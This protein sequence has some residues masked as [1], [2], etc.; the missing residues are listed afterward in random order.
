[1]DQFEQ[2]NGIAKAERDGFSREQI[3]KSFYVQTEGLNTMQRREIITEFF[4]REK[5]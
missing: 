1:M 5:K 2:P 3:M 4:D